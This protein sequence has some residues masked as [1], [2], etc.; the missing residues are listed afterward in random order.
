MSKVSTVN[1]VKEHNIALVR[2][3]IH[4]SVEFTKH[5]EIGRAH[6]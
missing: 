6:V 2:D 4:S 3:V 5:S 1:Q